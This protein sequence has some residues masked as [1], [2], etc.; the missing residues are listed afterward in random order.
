MRLDASNRR[1]L[2]KLAVVASAMFG[3]GWAMIPLYD[4][5]CEVT[6]VNSLT[7]V[8]RQAAEFA[9]NTQVDM[10]RKVVVEFDANARGPWRFQSETP[11]L[12]VHPGELVTVAFDVV[13]TE[14]RVV[15]GQAIP[16]YAPQS[17]AGFFRKLECF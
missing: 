2:G 1:L 4:T 14:D 11:A 7:R 12:V 9:R 17:S 5:I 3:F 6:G 10:S 13:N 16:S 8:D 15:A